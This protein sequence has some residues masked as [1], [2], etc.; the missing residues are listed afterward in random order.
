MERLHTVEKSFYNFHLAHKTHLADRVAHGSLLCNLL[1]Q[2]HDLVNDLIS[3]G[4]ILEQQM[5]E[6]Q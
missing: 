6:M 5:F 1:K 3:D 2:G 4:D